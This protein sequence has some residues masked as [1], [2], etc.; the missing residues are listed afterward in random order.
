MLISINW[1][2]NISGLP[3]VERKFDIEV[4]YFDL[5]RFIC[6]ILYIWYESL[7]FYP[8]PDD[9]S[10]LSYGFEKRQ[11]LGGAQVKRTAYTMTYFYV[12]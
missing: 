6:I 1:Y 10:S 4:N 2:V 5:R 12:T 3:I 7:L 8:V 9:V 11:R